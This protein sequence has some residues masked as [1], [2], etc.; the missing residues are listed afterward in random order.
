MKPELQWFNWKTKAASK[1][2]LETIRKDKQ[3]LVQEIRKAHRSWQAAQ[4][5]FEFALEKD[6]VDYAIYALEAAEKRYEML[7]KQAK[8]Q[9]LKL[10]EAERQLGV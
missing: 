7:L 4:A 6:Q 3:E 10:S 8:Q 5:H 9:Q 1:A 2:E